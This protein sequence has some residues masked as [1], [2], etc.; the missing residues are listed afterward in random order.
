MI[1]FCRTGRGSRQ[2]TLYWFGGVHCRT[3]RPPWRS[4]VGWRR[5][6]AGN[7][8]GRGAAGL[9]VLLSM[10]WTYGRR[11]CALRPFLLRAARRRAVMLAV[12]WAG[13]AR[14]VRLAP[15][16]AVRRVQARPGVDG[17][18][19]CRAGR[20]GLGRGSRVGNLA[21]PEVRRW[22]SMSRPIQHDAA[23]NQECTHRQ[24]PDHAFDAPGSP[25]L[26]APR[27]I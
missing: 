11:L 21:S 16:G 24:R 4:L 17:C 15:A 19:H 3:A 26:Q 20:P 14:Q 2:R 1:L 25:K 6:G 5:T 12:G 7:S 23:Q 18:Q 27:S 22:A 9:A 8:E 13:T 10:R